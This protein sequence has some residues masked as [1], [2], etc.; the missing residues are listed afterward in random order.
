MTARVAAALMLAALA[1]AACGKRG[2]LEPPEGST[3]PRTY[4]APETVVPQTDSPDS[5]DSTDDAPT[6][7]TT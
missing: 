6:G 4:P 5:T 2:T 3:Y 1:A 7:S